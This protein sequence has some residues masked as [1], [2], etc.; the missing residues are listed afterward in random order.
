MFIKALLSIFLAR[1]C[2]AISTVLQSL[3]KEFSYQSLR[4]LCKQ[5]SQR[6]DLVGFFMGIG[7]FIFKKH[8][9]T[10]TSILFYT[11]YP[12]NFLTDLG[13]NLKKTSTSSAQRKFMAPYYET[14]Q[15]IT[16]P[17]QYLEKS[18]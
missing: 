11:L 15:V 13:Q 1:L 17:S 10:L 18:V 7:C 14:T 2:N 4:N 9:Y 5:H 8:L 3:V 12:T 16:D 6:L